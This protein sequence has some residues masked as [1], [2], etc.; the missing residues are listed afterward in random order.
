M[1]ELPS[2]SVSPDEGRR[3]FLERAGKL[4]AYT[5]PLILTLMYPGAHAVASGALPP[6]AEA[7]NTPAS[8]YN[9][10]CK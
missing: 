2:D 8:K 5:P 7:C 6:E 4:A 10:L 1:H 9:P 3:Q